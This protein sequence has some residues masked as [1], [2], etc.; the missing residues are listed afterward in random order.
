MFSPR[1]VDSE[2]EVF[3]NR[4][5]SSEETQRN[6]ERQQSR[7]RSATPTPPRP[8]ETAV[9]ER[10]RPRS[11]SVTPNP[12]YEPYTR[13][14]SRSATPTPHTV[15]NPTDRS[16]SRSILV[17]PN[18]QVER[19]MSVGINTS[20]ADEQPKNGED[21]VLR[22]ILS[23]MTGVLKDLRDEMRSLKQN[24]QTHDDVGIHVH[25]SSSKQGD[26]GRIGPAQLPDNV[27]HPPI[28]PR[29]R[30]AQREVTSRNHRDEYDEYDEYECDEY[31]VDP[32][33]RQDLNG[34]RNNNNLLP[35]QRPD[36]GGHFRQ[37]PGNRLRHFDQ[38]CRPTPRDLGRLKISP[39]SGK[40]DW[41][42]WIARFEAISRRF[43]LGEDDKLDQLLPKLEGQAAEFAFAQL[44]PAILSNYGALV[45]E[46]NCRF[47]V[48]ETARS[49]A[50]KFSR[51]SQRTGE[52]A[53]EFAADLKTLYD[54]AH[55]FRDKKTRDEDLVR[56]FL[57]GLR[58]DEIRFMVEYNKEPETIDEAVFHVV[59]LIQTRNLRDRDRRPKDSTRMAREDEADGKLNE[60]I[61]SASKDGCHGDEDK[62]K[63]IKQLLD[64]IE[65]LEKEKR[66]GGENRKDVQCFA[67][68]QRGHY[69]RDCPNA[70]GRHGY[71]PRGGA[72]QRNTGWNRRNFGQGR[73]QNQEPTG[74]LNGQGLNSMVGGRS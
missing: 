16:R 15:I 66:R 1:A 18:E 67:C 3:F 73:I 4:G 23:G 36:F 58:D 70:P 20:F 69:A 29:P 22:D 14:R 53:E 42:V 7:S 38:Q 21:D 71:G 11:R 60:G 41:G 40:E 32:V 46:L 64:K 39:F 5:N 57:D 10:I 19:R 2:G 54:K 33:H 6:I 28:Q 72:N 9:K 48:I 59:N 43:C 68:D 50:A 74:H 24:N 34:G 37:G 61:P 51:R 44:P 65:S 56:R 8:N 45:K 30:Q 12:L 49:F 26:E 63:I 55:G 17:S 35:M 13:P 52:T 27:P 31:N 47:R 25:R 62:D